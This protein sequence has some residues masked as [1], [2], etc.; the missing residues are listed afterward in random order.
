MN[1]RVLAA[2]QWLGTG[3]KI[4][5]VERNGNGWT[6]V[7]STGSKI[8]SQMYP[9]GLKTWDTPTPGTTPAPLT[10]W[11]SIEK[12]NQMLTEYKVRKYLTDMLHDYGDDWVD[13]NAK[14]EKGCNNVYYNKYGEVVARCIAAEVLY[15]HGVTDEN[16]FTC[17]SVGIGQT[18]S[19]LNVEADPSALRMLH[20]AQS[21]QDSGAS[22]KAAVAAA[23]AAVYNLKE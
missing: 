5:R 21:A 9:G 11:P 2:G 12:D 14:N 23:N 4:I 16:L 8:T 6:V 17:N 3:N 7:D 15:R 19:K 10:P 20:V 1:E 13:P 18:V 22:W